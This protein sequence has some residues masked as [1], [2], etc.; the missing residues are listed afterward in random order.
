MECI[1]IA[2]SL[3]IIY[4]L[5]NN[6]FVKKSLLGELKTQ[7]DHYQYLLKVSEYKLESKKFINDIKNKQIEIAESEVKF[8]KQKASESKPKGI[9]VNWTI[10]K[11]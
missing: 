2:L 3:I 8:W 11:N 10:T 6:Y 7:K 5:I 9:Y 1:I 4:I